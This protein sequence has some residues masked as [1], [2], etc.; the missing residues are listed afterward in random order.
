M[1]GVKVIAAYECSGLVTYHKAG[2]LQIFEWGR[3]RV[4][5]CQNPG[6]GDS[7]SR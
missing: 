1:G 2:L 6:G 4:K 5:S 3:L 7:S